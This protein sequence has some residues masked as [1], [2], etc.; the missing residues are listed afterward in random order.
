MKL[1]APSVRKGEFFL[2]RN[3]ITLLTHRIPCNLDPQG[4]CGVF[5]IHKTGH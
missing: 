3:F 2:T 1:I 4:T 5:L